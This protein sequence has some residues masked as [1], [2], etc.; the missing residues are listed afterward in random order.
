MYFVISVV[1]N[2]QNVLRAKTCFVNE[3]LLFIAI[4]LSIVIGKKGISKT[5]AKNPVSK[6]LQNSN[7]KKTAV[8]IF[9][10]NR[11][12]FNFQSNFSNTT[13]PSLGTIG[14]AEED[15]LRILSFKFSI[16]SQEFVD[17]GLCDSIGGFLSS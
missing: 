8:P 11:A 12:I 16:W 6:M 7:F 9:I 10:D 14:L 3:S 13:L 4:Q 15:K 5:C 1:E 17:R 2:E